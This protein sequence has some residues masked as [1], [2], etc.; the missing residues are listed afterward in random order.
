LTRPAFGDAL[1]Q[2]PTLGLA[3][4]S[5]KP[6]RSLLLAVAIIDVVPLELRVQQIEPRQVHV[7][8]EALE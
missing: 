8:Y 6:T 7:D 3:I 2:L 1:G 4:D 5:L